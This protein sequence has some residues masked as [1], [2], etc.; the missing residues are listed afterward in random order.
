MVV[1]AGNARLTCRLA[2]RSVSH[3]KNSATA[4]LELDLCKFLI[5]SA[6]DQVRPLE[7]LRP[8]SRDGGLLSGEYLPNA[9]DEVPKDSRNTK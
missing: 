4:N 7:P 1:V 6:T 5:G 8:A 3:T 2:P 9:T